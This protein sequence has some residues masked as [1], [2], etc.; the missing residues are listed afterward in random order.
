VN[1]KKIS[2]KLS[3]FIEANYLAKLLLEIMAQNNGSK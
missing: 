3:F 2:K 1:N